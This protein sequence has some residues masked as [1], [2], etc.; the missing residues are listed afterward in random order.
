MQ[1]SS[2]LTTLACLGSDKTPEPIRRALAEYKSTATEL[3]KTG[4]YSGL[5]VAVNSCLSIEAE[6]T[7][8]IFVCPSG[9]GK[10]QA[11]IALRQLDCLKSPQ[12]VCPG[13]CP[14]FKRMLASTLASAGG[15][16]PELA[17]P[18]FPKNCGIII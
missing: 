1:L 3:L 7:F 18:Q 13:L 16:T 9:A 12:V 4:Y 11:G 2:F 15:A 8:L 5:I 14:I 6:G 10:T 17:G